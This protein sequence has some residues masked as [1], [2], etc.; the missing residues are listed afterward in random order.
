M[1]ELAKGPYRCRVART[2]A[3][4]RRAQWLRQRCFRPGTPGRDADAFDDR[5]THFLVEARTGSD[6]GGDTGGELVCCFRVL[7][8][9]D[10]RALEHSYSAQFYD[11]SA[12]ARLEM[13]TVEMGRFCVDPDRRDPDILRLAWGALTRHVDAHGA[14]M[15]IGCASF[16][17]TDAGPYADAFALLGQRHRAPRRWRPRVKAPRVVRFAA[18]GAG[19]DPA[20]AMRCMPPLLRSY[21]QMGGRVSDHAVIDEALQTLHVFT[22]VEVGAIPPARRRLLRAVAS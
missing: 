20:G 1:P 13:P 11:L 10:G 19:A 7:T 21:L 17:G 4:I 15:L 12:L 3:D 9:D 22:G 6:T 8:L 16:R 18:G 14:E 5:C 2:Q